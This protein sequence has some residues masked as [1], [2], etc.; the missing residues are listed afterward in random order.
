MKY[1]KD[2]IGLEMRV[3]DF[4]IEDKTI[5]GVDDPV[6]TLTLLASVDNGPKF[7]VESTSKV[8]IKTIETMDFSDGVGKRTII[9]KGVSKEGN[10]YYYFV[11]GL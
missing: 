10:E 11:K 6:K 4:K 3:W 2:V 1:A 8:L 9:Q 5:T 7:E